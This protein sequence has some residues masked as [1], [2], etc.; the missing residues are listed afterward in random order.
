M[1]AKEIDTTGTVEYAWNPNYLN[2]PPYRVRVTGKG[3]TEGYQY[4]HQG[5]RP[6][7]GW[8]VEVLDGRTPPPGKHHRTVDGEPVAQSRDLLGEWDVYQAQQAAERRQ[9]DLKEQAERAIHLRE[10]AALD[11][12]NADFHWA[13]LQVGTSRPDTH[14]RFDSVTLLALL[15]TVQRGKE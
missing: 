5:P 6:T 1:K 14:M 7:S 4:S 8:I 3:M 10:A 9:R 2:A 15:Q 11:V 12:L 13:F